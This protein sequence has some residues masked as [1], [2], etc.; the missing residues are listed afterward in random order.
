VKGTPRAIKPTRRAAL[1]LVCRTA[2]LGQ[3]R[4]KP[5]TVDIGADQNPKIEYPPLGIV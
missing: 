1:L 4:V 3:L 2:A 5:L